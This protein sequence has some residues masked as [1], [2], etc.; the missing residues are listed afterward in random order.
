MPGIFHARR[1][2]NQQAR[3]FELRGHIGQLKLHALKLIDRFAKLLALAR[4]S[5]RG[6]EGTARDADHLGADADA[7]FV[8]VSIEVL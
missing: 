3:G 4:V 8:K 6:V 2:V 5:N 1:V 7:A